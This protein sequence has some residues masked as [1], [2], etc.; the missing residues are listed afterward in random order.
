MILHPDGTA[1]GTPE[2]LA[3]FH[4]ARWP[5]ATVPQYVI[6]IP[7]GPQSPSHPYAPIIRPLVTC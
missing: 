3:A 7:T 5:E 6:P 4:Q 1:E 2:E